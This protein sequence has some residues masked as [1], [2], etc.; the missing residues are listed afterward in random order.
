MEEAARKEAARPKFTAEEQLYLLNNY[1]S[2]ADDFCKKKQ[3][4]SDMSFMDKLCL[5]KEMVESS[6]EISDK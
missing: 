2:L 6:R 5:I 4:D 3:V 1:E